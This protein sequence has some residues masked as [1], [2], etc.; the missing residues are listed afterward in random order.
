MKLCVTYM[1]I[2]VLFLDIKWSKRQRINVTLPP[3]K[4]NCQ[5]YGYC[6]SKKWFCD[7]AL[8][9]LVKVHRDR[10]AQEARS[11]AQVDSI[12]GIARHFGIYS[13]GVGEATL[14]PGQI[15]P[16]ECMDGKLVNVLYIFSDRPDNY[17]QRPTQKQVDELT[18]FVG[19]E[20]QWWVDS[21]TGSFFE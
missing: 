15:V 9:F 11:N 5:V 7:T 3:P 16:V 20:P 6:V 14:P 2:W 12:Y 21:S 1:Y 8:S 13:M 10:P 19:R 4:R 17:R 18:K